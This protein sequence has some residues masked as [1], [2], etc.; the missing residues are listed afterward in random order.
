MAIDHDFMTIEVHPQISCVILGARLDAGS[1]APKDGADPRDKFTDT[2]T[3]HNEIDILIILL[4]TIFI[5]AGDVSFL[6]SDNGNCAHHSAEVGDRI[7]STIEH[8]Q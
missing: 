8:N 3:A 2:L 5:L 7:G 1:S 6:D 4:K